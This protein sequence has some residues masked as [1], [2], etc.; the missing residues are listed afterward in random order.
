MTWLPTPK[1]ATVRLAFPAW[2]S[3]AWPSIV[4]P[5]VKL[6]VPDG[7]PDPPPAAATTT[8]KATFC[9]KTDGLGAAVSTAAVELLLTVCVPATDVE[10][11]KLGVPGYLAVMLWVPTESEATER[12]AFPLVSRVA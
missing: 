3:V 6:T 1:E 11:R 2:S 9:P 4:G 7:V 5:S 12:T 8:V 10:A